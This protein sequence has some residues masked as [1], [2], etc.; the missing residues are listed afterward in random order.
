MGRLEEIEE[1]IIY[2]EMVLN[3]T[4]TSHNFTS[5]TGYLDI[6]TF[7]SCHAHL[8]LA[9]T[10]TSWRKEQRR[11]RTNVSEK[12]RQDTQVEIHYSTGRESELSE[13]LRNLISLRLKSLTAKTNRK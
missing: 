6:I 9:R 8:S 4:G 11:Q 1:N 13:T 10:Q 3:L 5:L 2:A 12:Q 7:V